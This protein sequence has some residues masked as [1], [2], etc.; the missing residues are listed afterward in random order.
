MDSPIII[1]ATAGE[2][3][4]QPFFYALGHFSKFLVPGSV[5]VEGKVQVEQNKGNPNQ[6]TQVF[7]LLTT[8]FLRPDNGTVLTV[9]NR[10]SHSV[11]VKVHDQKRGT[12]E[13]EVPANCLQTFVWY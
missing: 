9:L 1:N 8:V 11:V 4:R 3:Y 5:R 10:N 2:Y 12:L 13:T 6:N 7:S